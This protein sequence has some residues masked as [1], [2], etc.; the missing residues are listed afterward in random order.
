[1]ACKEAATAALDELVNS[2]RAYPEDI[3]PV[4]EYI[5]AL[6]NPEPPAPAKSAKKAKKAAKK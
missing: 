4:R 3:A 6:E 5:H 1:M 2:G